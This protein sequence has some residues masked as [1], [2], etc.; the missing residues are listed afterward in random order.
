MEHAAA[1]TIQK[2]F[3][4]YLTRKYIRE[5]IEHNAAVNI[6]RLWRGHRGRQLARRERLKQSQGNRLSQ[7]SQRESA[8]RGIFEQEEYLLQ[9][10]SSRE[11]DVRSNHNY[12]ERWASI[13]EEILSEESV[14]ENIKKKIENFLENQRKE[15]TEFEYRSNPSARSSLSSQVVTNEIN[16]ERH[17]LAQE[18]LRK[19]HPH[20]LGSPLAQSLSPGHLL[21]SPSAFASFPFN[22]LPTFPFNSPQA[23]LSP[24]VNSPELLIES[25][26]NIQKFHKERLHSKASS[27]KEELNSMLIRNTLS[28][29]THEKKYKEVESCLESELEKF[30]QSINE[31]VKN[32]IIYKQESPQLH[33]HNSL[34]F[35][36]ELMITPKKHLV[37]LSLPELPEETCSPKLKAREADPTLRRQDERSLEFCDYYQTQRE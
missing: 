31:I 17:F 2:V 18:R 14:N 33:N 16:S 36:P 11:E 20:T 24:G 22:G 7:T 19:E 6:Q 13:L 10:S 35:S 29:R 21:K 25:L 3:R 32:C 37:E 34:D 30:N 1:V 12:T 9:R 28:P 5:C 27:E 4:G 23:C 8:G 15:M 26:K